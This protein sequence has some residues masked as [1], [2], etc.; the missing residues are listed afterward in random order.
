[1]IHLWWGSSL[2]EV[3]KL[4][5]IRSNNCQPLKPCTNRLKN[6]FYP[7]S[8]IAL[9]SVKPWAI[10]AMLIKHY[11]I[12]PMCNN[13]T[14]KHC[15]LFYVPYLNLPTSFFSISTFHRYIF[16]CTADYVCLCRSLHCLEYLSN[17]VVLLQWQER[18]LSLQNITTL[19]LCLTLT[20][21]DRCF[22]PQLSKSNVEW[23]H[24]GRMHRTA[25]GT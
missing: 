23:L 1:M 22:L 13:L 4:T 24:Q 5:G 16:Y 21:C 3:R 11:L 9:K 15:A 19:F 12:S 10:N 2:K 17:F 7:R 18:H 8:V 6:R 25:R 20:K 14:N